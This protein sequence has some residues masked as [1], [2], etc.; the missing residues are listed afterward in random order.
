MHESAAIPEE[1]SNENQ[2]QVDT[3]PKRER[4]HTFRINRQ[5]TRIDI[6]FVGHLT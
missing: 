1:K 4:R 5:R 3:K 6:G 2:S